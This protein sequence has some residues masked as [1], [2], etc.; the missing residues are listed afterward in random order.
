MIAAWLLFCNALSFDL[1]WWLLAGSRYIV[2]VGELSR[3]R[4][5]VDWVAPDLPLRGDA[6]AN[7]GNIDGWFL[8]FWRL[9]STELIGPELS[10]PR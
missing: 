9:R 3:W 5:N 10:Q 2:V 7:L 1:M 4:N 6:D 8:M